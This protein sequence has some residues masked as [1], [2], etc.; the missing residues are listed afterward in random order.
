MNRRIFFLAGLLVALF[1][2][3]ASAQVRVQGT[4]KDPEG[5]PIKG[6]T[7][8][9]SNEESSPVAPLTTDQHGKWRVLLPIGGSWNIDIKAEGYQTNRGSMQIGELSRT[10]PIETVLQPIP[11]E[12]PPQAGPSVPPEAIEALESGQ[13]LMKEQKYSEAVVQ[14]EKA[15]E[16]LPKNLQLD[17]LL[18]QGYY[19]AGQ[20]EKAISLLEAVH[21]EEPDNA[22]VTLLLTN[23]L[24]EDGQFEKGKAMLEQVPESA[25]TDP[26]AL[27]NVGILFMNKS[28]LD[29]ALDYFNRAVAVA[30]DRGES[31][32]YRGIAE[33]QLKKM[34][35]AKADLEKVLELAPDSGE[36]GD[37]KD[38]LEQMK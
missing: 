37:A 12:A 20:V 29:E 26:T 4:V 18:A 10:P 31:Y 32:Y 23:L 17:Q 16:L 25:M 35:Q 38:L 5:K 13:N 15:R 2:T 19:K 36:A 11:K 28:Q 9:F 34:D 33:L 30:P 6:A 3:V 24:L 22:A 7:V 27:I 21:V 14:L 1:A 8:I